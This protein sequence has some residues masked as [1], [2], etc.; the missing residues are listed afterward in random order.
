M[1]FS[2]GSAG[3]AI[4][5]EHLGS[6]GSSKMYEEAGIPQRV[7]AHDNFEQGEMPGSDAAD[8]TLAKEVDNMKLH[9][10]KEKPECSKKKQ[11][12]VS[13]KAKAPVTGGIEGSK[14]RK[15][16]SGVPKKVPGGRRSRNLVIRDEP[17]G[18]E[19]MIPAIRG[20]SS[21]S[22]FGTASVSLDGHGSVLGKRQVDGMLGFD[23]VADVT[24]AMVPFVAAAPG[25]YRR[26]EYPSADIAKGKTVISHQGKPITDQEENK[27]TNVLE[28]RW[29]QPPRGWTK[30]NVDG[31]FNAE[32][33]TSRACMILRGEGGQVIFS[34]CRYLR[35][36]SS[37]LEVELMACMEGIAIARAW[38]ELPMIIETDCL[39]AARM[40]IQDGMNRS[41]C[42][43]MVT[44]IQ[45]NLE[46]VGE[47]VISHV[48]RS[49]NKT[50]DALAHIGHVKQRTA[51]WLHGIRRRLIPYS[52]VASNELVDVIPTP[53]A[54]EEVQARFS[55]R[56]SGV[57]M[58]HV[59]VR[60]EKMAKKRNLQGNE[61]LSGNSFDGLSNMEIISSALQMGVNILDDS[62]AVI[63]V[64]RELEK[65]RANIAKK[66]SNNEKQEDNLLLISNTAGESSPLNTSW[67][68]EGDLDEEGFKIVKSRKKERK[69][70]N[71]VISKPLTRSQNQKLSGVAGKTMDPGKPGNK[72]QSPKPI[73]WALWLA[74]NRAT[75]EKKWINNPFEIVFTSCAFMQYLTGHQCQNLASRVMKVTSGMNGELVDCGSCWW[76]SRA[77]AG[78]VPFGLGASMAPR[79]SWNTF[80]ARMVWLGVSWSSGSSGWRVTFRRILEAR[81]QDGKRSATPPRP[82]VSNTARASPTFSSMQYQR[83]ASVPTEASEAAVGGEANTTPL[84]VAIGVPNAGE[85]GNGAAATLP[86]VAGSSRGAGESWLSFG[87]SCSTCALVVATGSSSML[88]SPKP[89]PRP[90][91]KAKP[92]PYAQRGGGGSASAAVR[93]LDGLVPHHPRLRVTDKYHL[94]RGELGV[95]RLATNRGAARER[96]ACKSI[97]QA[98]L[99]IAVDVAD[100]RREVAIMASLPDHPALVR[101]RAA[102][103][104]DDA[105]HLVMELC[106]GG[107]LFDRIVARGRYTERAAAAAAR[108]V[109]EI[110]AA[111][112]P[113]AEVPSYFL[114]PISLELMRDPVTLPT[115]ISYDRAAIS[116]WLAASA[117]P[118]ACSTSQRTCPVTRQ[119]L[120][121]ELQ[122]TPNHNILALKVFEEMRGAMPAP[123]M[124]ARLARK[125][126]KRA[127]SGC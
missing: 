71:V 116:R 19:D 73:C 27:N 37:A 7:D 122:L 107:E 124:W 52:S 24:N 121:P 56:T 1:S 83:G 91:A 74:R 48:V 47:H 78:D 33:H 88:T 82:S 43:T 119:P 105:V 113:P 41:P 112:A 36:C 39:T 100:V 94:G 54:I 26:K 93:V 55:K 18:S 69:K 51:V 77:D 109:A 13:F 80:S 44:Q 53:P 3:S 11:M 25:E 120:E 28:E 72:T 31:A 126:V 86:G 12:D 21:L 96:L 49:R 29:L 20:L 58:E 85:E 115:G 45:W 17:L 2:F 87:A 46:E 63:D 68:D 97:R 15:K 65:S 16:K 14:Q 92:N 62:F 114:C 38:S 64:I 59:G 110:M 95:T 57:N 125:T 34:S 104:D 111:M 99:R 50:A 8:Q 60:A 23:L 30:L 67:G 76:N 106:D 108:T 61:T 75:F 66:I 127:K 42:A 123:D 22:L 89:R 4:N 117:T 98:R 10:E 103:E 40:I 35:S 9:L 6:S 32:N 81:P 102:F 79:I 101:L 70:V 84:G 90:R 5:V 118:A